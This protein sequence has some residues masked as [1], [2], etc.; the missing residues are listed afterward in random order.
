MPIVTGK[1]LKPKCPACG[2]DIELDTNTYYNFVGEIPCS[3]CK[4]VLVV[5]ISNGDLTAIAKLRDR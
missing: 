4:A 5:G 1:I 3:S 2:K